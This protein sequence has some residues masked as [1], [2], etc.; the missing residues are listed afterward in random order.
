MRLKAF[1]LIVVFC[2]F[3]HSGKLPVDE[4]ILENIFVSTHESLN[5][6]ENIALV[7]F[8]E[9][10]TVRLAKEQKFCGIFTHNSNALTQQLASSVFGY[11][12]LIDLQVNQ[13]IVNGRKPFAIVP[14]SV[15]WI[16]QWKK[17]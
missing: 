4:P 12:T 15:R 3:A 9:N 14:D 8:M 10:E 1:Q 5:A 2:S 13:F 17:F 16:L 6:Q 7:T 11:E